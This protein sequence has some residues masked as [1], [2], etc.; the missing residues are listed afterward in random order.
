MASN[1]MLYVP[2]AMTISSGIQEIL[3]YYLNKLRDCSVGITVGNDFMKYAA[4]M[5]SGGMS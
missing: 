2:R 3:G 1:G 4:E 5:V